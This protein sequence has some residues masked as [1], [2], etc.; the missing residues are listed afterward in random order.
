MRIR[1]KLTGAL[2]GLVT[3]ILVNSAAA[4]TPISYGQTLTGTISAAAEKDEFS[5]SGSSGQGITVRF[6]RT[7]GTLA[8]YAELYNPSGAKV[9]YT[10]T[11]S[12]DYKLNAAGTWKI[13]IRDSGNTNTG[14]YEL[15]LQCTTAPINAAVLSFGSSNAGTLSTPTDIDAFRL[16]VSANDMVT[17]RAVKTAGLSGIFTPYIELYNTT[18]G[19]AGYTTT[20]IL[21]KKATPGGNYSVFFTDNQR[22]G[23]GMYSFFTQR[24]NNPAGADA[25]NFGQTVTGGVDPAESMRAYTF[26]ASAGDVIYLTSAKLTQESGGFSP[27]VELYDAQGNSIAYAS[28]G[29]M[30]K[31]V[32]ATAQYSIVVSDQLMDGT[33]TFEY[34]LQ[35]ANNPANVTGAGYGVTIEGELSGLSDIDVY[36]F[37]AT[38]NSNITVCSA[39]RVQTQGLF[40]PYFELYN[41]SGTRVKYAESGFQYKF[42]STGTY[43]LFVTDYNKD[44][45]GIYRFIISQGNVSCSS[46]DLENPEVSLLTPQPGEVVSNGAGYNITWSAGDD[47][48]ITA[49]EIRLSVDGGA[50]YPAVVAASLSGSARSYNWAVP[51][52]LSASGARLKVTAWDAKGN[53]GWNVT[54]GDFLIANMTMPSGSVNTSYGY[55]KENRLI[56]STGANYTFDA[57]GNRLSLN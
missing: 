21:K 50:A 28:T 38:A 6:V 14:N 20:G 51:S 36:R 17:V 12:L 4:A 40:S 52:N 5:F 24:L 55:D 10:G 8:A 13:L 22:D 43:R 33:G 47:K 54:R 16:N 49:Q 26:N 15:T 1:F 57:L 9:S 45:A 42:N 19:K 41:S 37:N 34:T 30:E 3:L 23:T 27:Y 46:I 7:S 32:N 48:G 56:N 29:R 39:V 2:A 18:G 44:G 25:V 35:R 53:Q 31:K 11:G